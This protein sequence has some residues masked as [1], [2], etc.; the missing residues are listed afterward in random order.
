MLKDA[1]AQLIE[2]YAAGGDRFAEAVHGWSEADLVRLPSAASA[3][4]VGQWSVHELAIHVADAELGFADRI[5]RVI[6]MDE[7]AL[8]VWHENAFARP[9][10]L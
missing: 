1:T 9:A 10:A 4:E 2:K 3:A 6:A 8:L 5:R 7:P